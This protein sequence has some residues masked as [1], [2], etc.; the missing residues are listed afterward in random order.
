MHSEKQ[1]AVSGAMAATLLTLLVLQCGI[2][3]AQDPAPISSLEVKL[4]KQ[5]FKNDRLSVYLL[6]I[7]PNQASLMHRHDTDLLSVFVSGGETKSTILGSPPKEDTF[8]VGAVRFRP[9]GFT[10][11]T[12]N[13]GASIFRSV[14]VEF[15]SSMGAIEPGKPDDSHYCNSDAKSACVDVKYLFCTAKFCVQDVRIDPRA[16]WRNDD[17]GDRLR[18]AVSDYRFSKHFRRSGEVEFFSRGS[19]KH[20]KNVGG[21]PA[22]VVEVVFR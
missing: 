14:V 20:W 22:R 7:P 18:V 5:I 13:I 16:V 8:A 1:Q 4:R 2:A 10:H 15:T 21:K 12:E 17:T 9:A 19:A 3:V 11:S 6:E